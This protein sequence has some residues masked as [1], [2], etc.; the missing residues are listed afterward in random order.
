VN[1]PSYLT[2]DDCARLLGLRPA[3][4]RRAAR[5]AH[6]PP[7]ASTQHGEPCWREDDVLRWAA[8]TNSKLATRIPLRYWPE[9]TTPAVYLGASAH[10]DAVVMSWQTTPGT[11]ALVW[12][13]ID[14]IT[15][16]LTDYL[17]RATD[18]T[19]IVNVDPD[20]GIDGP[21]L[22]AINTASP[23]TQNGLRWADLARVLG[24]PMPY[25]PLPLPL[26]EIICAWHPGAGPITA[27]ARPDI[28]TTPLLRLAAIFE[29][30]HPA[31]RTLLNLA[32]IAQHRATTA[33]LQDLEFLYESINCGLGL[34]VPTVL[35]AIP[36]PVPE[37]AREDIDPA[38]R[39]AG[40]LDVL[41]G[42]DTLSMQ[43]VREV[44]AWDGGID[45]PFS[46]PEEIDPTTPPGREWA[47]RLRPTPRTA[48]FELIDYHGAGDTLT[49]PAT[50]APAVRRTDG[51]LI[52]AIPQRLPAT[53]PL[54]TLTLAKDHIWVRTQDGTLYPAPTLPGV[55][56][57]WGYSGGGP[58]ALATLIDCLLDDI[59]AA[60]PHLLLSHETPQGLRRLT[61]TPWSAGTTLNRDQLDAARLG[62]PP[63]P[64]HH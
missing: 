36:L 34:E 52:A 50:D 4:L 25:W 48:A 24:Q 13:F 17:H 60:A 22:R 3:Q 53:H 16:D 57:S 21:A 18:A 49:D 14:P 35:A 12:N 10:D 63:Q 29:P 41:G 28:D 47:Q 1:D 19:I 43:C 30:E 2:L 55:G 64:P 51:H 56:L 37:A 54:A 44:K 8:A 46:N 33:A 26:P 39:R 42:A 45:F 5:E 38:T 20:F 11:V 15:V 61:Q 9:T 59:N 23:D 31:H 6:F 27:P 40:W 7:A 58:A 32:R 62:D